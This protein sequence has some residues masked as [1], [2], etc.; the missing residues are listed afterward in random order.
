MGRFRSLY[1]V[2]INTDRANRLPSFGTP[3]QKFSCTFGVNQ[4]I[5]TVQI[6]GKVHPIRFTYYSLKT[7]TLFKLINRYCDVVPPHCPYL[8]G[9]RPSHETSASLSAPDAFSCTWMSDTV[10]QYARYVPSTNNLRHSKAAR[11]RV[12]HASGFGP[13]D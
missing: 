8:S 3:H 12:Q 2:T 4:V 11:V 1:G 6:C 7:V 13:H 9:I 10:S 5:R